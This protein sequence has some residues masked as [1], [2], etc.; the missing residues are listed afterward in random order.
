MDFF[1]GRN[2]LVT[3]HDGRSLTIVARKEIF[4]QHDRVLA[5]GLVTLFHRIVD[6]IVDYDMPEFEGLEQPINELEE[7][8]ILGRSRSDACC[9]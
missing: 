7:Q 5:E 9:E 2:Y 8:A 6:S 3:V 1:L 4:D